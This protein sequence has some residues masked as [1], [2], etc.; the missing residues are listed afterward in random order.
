[1]STETDFKD[2]LQQ[3]DNLANMAERVGTQEFPFLLTATTKGIWCRS[4]L[5]QAV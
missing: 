4:G 3:L 1:M 2:L 5:I